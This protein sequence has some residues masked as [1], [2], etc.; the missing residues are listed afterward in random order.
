MFLMIFLPINRDSEPK[1]DADFKYIVENFVARLVVEIFY[2][3]FY[4]FFVFMSRLSSLLLTPQ[5]TS[6]CFLM[7]FVGSFLLLTCSN[8]VLK[9]F[10]VLHIQHPNTVY[11]I[12]MH[13]SN[14]WHC[15]QFKDL[16]EVSYTKNKLFNAKKRTKQVFR[17]S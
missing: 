7:T 11:E 8:S 13:I 14:K 17:G 1:F 5:N 4:I 10:A 2:Y 12:M 15:T 16:L 9:C 6:K 3:I